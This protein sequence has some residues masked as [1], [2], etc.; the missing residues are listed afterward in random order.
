MTFEQLQMD[1]RAYNQDR[2]GWSTAMSSV[3]IYGGMGWS[4]VNMCWWGWGSR[5]F[6]KPKW[7]PTGHI[8]MSVFL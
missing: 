3:G 6:S 4:G 5:T 7:L 2:N 1:D 8:Q